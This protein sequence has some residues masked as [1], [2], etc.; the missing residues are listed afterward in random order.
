MKHGTKC[1]SVFHLC[2]IRGYLI[3][4]AI[5]LGLASLAWACN[6]PVFRFAL[7]RWRPDPYRVVLLHKV[8]LTAADLETIRPLEEQQ[9]LASANFS[10]RTVDVDQI[11]EQSEES[12]ADAALLASLGDPELPT[13]VVHYPAGLQ[14]PKPVWTGPPTREAIDRLTDSPARKELARRLAEGQTAVWIVLETGEKERD[15]AAVALVEAEIQRLEKDLTLPELT[16]APED[17]LLAQTPLKIAFS[18]LRIR[19]DDPAEEMLVA[20][21]IGSEPDLAERKDDPLVFPVFGRGRALWPLVGAGITAK[22][23]HDS[24]SFLVGACSCEVKELNPGF[25][26]LLT[27]DWD[28][29]LATS[30]VEL[31]AAMSTP[32]EIPAEPQLVPI[33]A[34]AAAAPTTV[35]VPAPVV[36]QYSYV[37]YTP[38]GWLWIGGGVLFVALAFVAVVV[39]LSQSRG[40]DAQ[41]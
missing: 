7:E 22:N 11:D 2:S 6:V 3:A 16:A 30:G 1:S 4:S 38:M 33:P 9:E 19:K 24:A 37:P 29:L 32:T 18:T 10:L 26:L 12:A 28:E 23:I 13:I 17:A 31:T 41:T 27:A 40:R 20:M 36:V 39:A 15:E 34:G 14:I 25:D 8:P 5:L 35:T 21:L